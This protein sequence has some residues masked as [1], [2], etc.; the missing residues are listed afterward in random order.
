MLIDE[1][2][3]D[4]RKIQ[5]TMNNEREF[6]DSI[7]WLCEKYSGQP[8]ADAADIMLDVEKDH[9][10]FLFQQA[11]KM[12]RQMSAHIS[13]EKYNFRVIKIDS[14]SKAQSS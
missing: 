13:K 8:V 3:E 14:I 4:L 6:R 1:I 10:L 2:K 5:K 7:D 11:Y 12:N 9:Q